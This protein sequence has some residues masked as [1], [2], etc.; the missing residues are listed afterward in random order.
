MHFYCNLKKSYIR[1]HN[2]TFKVQ[3]AFQIMGEDFYASLFALVSGSL[4]NLVRE[5]LCFLS[6]QTIHLWEMYLYSCTDQ[7]STCS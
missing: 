2:I 4:I 1:I 6:H 7:K 5:Q 3:E